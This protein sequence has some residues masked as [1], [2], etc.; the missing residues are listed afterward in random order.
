MGLV[1]PPADDLW[2][3]FRSKPG[4]GK[5]LA[6]VNGHEVSVRRTGKY[7]RRKKLNTAKHL[8]KQSTTNG[9]PR[10]EQIGDCPY[11]FAWILYQRLLFLARW[12][13]GWLAFMTLEGNAKASLF[14]QD[15]SASEMSSSPTSWPAQPVRC[16]LG[17]HAIAISSPTTRHRLRM[18]ASI[19]FSAGIAVYT[20]WALP[21]RSHGSRPAER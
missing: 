21:A 17:H 10:A 20:G 13:E 18:K 5:K 15:S 1:Q 8:L 11:L 14:R 9:V 16:I 7:L 2:L 12:D 4:S 6:L 3:L 19:A